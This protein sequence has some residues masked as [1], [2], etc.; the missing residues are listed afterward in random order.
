MSPR[1]KSVVTHPPIDD[2]L[3]ACGLRFHRFGGGDGDL[4]GFAA[5]DEDA[6]VA[7]LLAP[8]D[9][10]GQGFGQGGLQGD[11][12]LVAPGDQQRQ[13]AVED[14]GDAL[15]RCSAYSVLL[16]LLLCLRRR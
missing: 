9:G 5:V 15:C 10:G 3:Q 12:L 14:E 1:D 2:P 7:D 13:V 11:A 4:G 8:F 16:L 6:D